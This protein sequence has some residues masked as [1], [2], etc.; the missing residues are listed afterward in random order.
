MLLSKGGCIALKPYIRSV[1][2]FPANQTHDNDG[3]FLRTQ[4]FDYLFII[5]LFNFI[6]YF[7]VLVSTVHRVKLSENKKCCLGN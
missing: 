4:D 1:H 5:N 3:F 7:S 2:V 6:V